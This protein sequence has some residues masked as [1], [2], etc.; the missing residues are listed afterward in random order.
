MQNRRNAVWVS[1]P[2][3][4]PNHS[5]HPHSDRLRELAAVMHPSRFAARL[6]AL[7]ST[8]T[9]LRLQRS[10]RLQ[11]RLAELAVGN[12]GAWNGSNW[13]RG[14]LLGHDPHRA[15][16][17]AGSVWHARS[18]LK[19][20]SR[21]EMETL[22]GNVGAEAH[23]FGIRNLSSAVATTSILDP[24]RLS[25]GIEH[26]GYACLGAWLDEASELDRKRV[27]LR[28]PVGTAAEAPATEHHRAAGQLLSL[29]MAH[30]ATEAPTA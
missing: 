13:G 22:I 17:L 14:V 16:L 2:S 30:L 15:A 18:L 11:E 5:P 27:L 29:V 12:E 25:Q 6:D 23:A 10:V 28:L 24:E 9:V 3:N 19:L 20:V 8:P 1:M 26:D 4:E 7:L 21:R